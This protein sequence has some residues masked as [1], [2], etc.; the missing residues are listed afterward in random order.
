MKKVKWVSKELLKQK[1][2]DDCHVYIAWPCIA[3]LYKYV[4]YL[5]T[6]I[7]CLPQYIVIFLHVVEL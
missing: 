5:W 1:N 2:T 7:I 3:K 6:Y 4:Y